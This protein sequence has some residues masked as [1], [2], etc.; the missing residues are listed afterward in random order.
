MTEL[1]LEQDRFIRSYVVDVPSPKLA[2]AVS[3]VALQKARLAWGAERRRVAGELDRLQASMVAAFK[4]SEQAAQMEKIAAKVQVTLQVIDEGLEDAL[5]DALNAQEPQV[6]EKE[7]ARCIVLIDRY[8]AQTDSHGV[9]GL[10]DANPFLRVDIV[11]GLRRV[12][13]D[14]RE[15]LS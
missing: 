13:I 10:L 8:L 14:L 4:G 1:S 9:I 2:Q 7:Q 6:R 3:L 5:D 15:T 11:P 12:L